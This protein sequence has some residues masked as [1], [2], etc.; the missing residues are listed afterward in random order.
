MC[1]KSPFRCSLA[2]ALALTAWAP[3]ALAASPE[4]VLM[5]RIL[6]MGDTTFVERTDGVRTPTVDPSF[7]K[8]SAEALAGSEKVEDGGGRRLLAPASYSLA[9]WQ[10]PIRDQM[11]RGTCGVFAAT[12]AIEAR[13]RRDYGL[14]L[15]LSEQYSHHIQKSVSL[16]YPRYYQ[17]ENQS[18]YWYGAGSWTISLGASYPLPLE[19]EAPYTSQAGLDAVRLSIPAAGALIWHPDAASNPTTQAQVDAFEY[20]P[21]YIPLSARRNARYGVSSYTLLNGAQARNT[22]LLEDY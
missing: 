12:A 3:A 4:P 2:L 18:S 17:Y 1:T 10:T 9:A 13:Y 5:R 22:A 16:S 20:S 21:L 15:D 19:S 8:P 11:D 6:R 7:F 14:S